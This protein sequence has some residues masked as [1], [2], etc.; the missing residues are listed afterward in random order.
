MPCDDNSNVIKLHDQLGLVDSVKALLSF[1]M[2][3]A[4]IETSEF[5]EDLTLI[6]RIQ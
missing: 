3:T 6:S 1:I 4:Q 2:A 5:R